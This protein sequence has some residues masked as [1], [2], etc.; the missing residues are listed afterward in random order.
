MFWA[1]MTLDGRTD[2]YVF[3]RG[4]ITALRNRSDILEL[5]SGHIQA[6]L[7]MHSF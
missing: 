6:L 1:V 7:V 5:L 3:D 2:L 4:G